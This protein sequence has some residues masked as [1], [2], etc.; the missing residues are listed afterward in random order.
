MR[1]GLPVHPALALLAWSFL[2]LRVPG[3]SVSGLLVVSACLLFG[4]S[5]A[6]KPFCGLAWRARWLFLS[7]WLILAY[8]Q[9][10][11]AWGNFAWAPTLEGIA[12]ANH[13]GLSLLVM[14]LALA[15][16]FECLGQ[17]GLLSGLWCLLKPLRHWGCDVTRVVVR[18]FLVMEALR[19]PLPRGAWKNALFDARNPFPDGP[20]HCV[21]TIP[22][23]TDRDSLVAFLVILF[24]YGVSWL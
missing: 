16:L 24:L 9:A 18:V 1:P 20:S 14:L 3:L 22:A 8:G 11:D 19:H 7:L 5:A 21:L 10:G 15:V 6:W 4:V 13:Q 2:L 23:W 12:E 17:E